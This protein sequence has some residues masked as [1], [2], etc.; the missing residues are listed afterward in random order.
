MD[1]DS[2]NRRSVIACD[3]KKL[4]ECRCRCVDC[5][6]NELSVVPQ[7]A[8]VVIRTSMKDLQGRAVPV[9]VYACMRVSV[10]FS[11][12]AV[13]RQSVTYCLSH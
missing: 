4:L 5:G 6:L 3:I 7:R 2:I 10:F 1:I 11:F 8:G 13:A 9:C 12:L